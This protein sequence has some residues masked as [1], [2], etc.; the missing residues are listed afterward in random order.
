MAGEETDFDEETEDEEPA[1]DVALSSASL[2]SPARGSSAGELAAEEESV[3]STAETGL[4]GCSCST[5]SGSPARFDAEVPDDAAD[6][7]GED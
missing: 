1:V 4:A 2:G 3:V 7:E 6:L 5:S